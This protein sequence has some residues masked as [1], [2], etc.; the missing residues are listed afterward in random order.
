M[1]GGFQKYPNEI[2]VVLNSLNLD[3]FE[4]VIA[5]L[6]LRK[7]CLWLHLSMAVTVSVQTVC[8]SCT[9]GFILHT[10]KLTYRLLTVGWLIIYQ[11]CKVLVRKPANF[12]S[13]VAGKR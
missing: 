5:L 12:V 3:F 6:A 10:K 8:S 2:R 4:K 9:T 1:V 7:S 13:F 11:D